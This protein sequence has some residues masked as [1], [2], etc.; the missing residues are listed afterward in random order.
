M[1][2]TSNMRA[3]VPIDEPYA[4]RNIGLVYRADAPEKCLR[5]SNT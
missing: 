4:K 5:S 2:R 1:V 3:I